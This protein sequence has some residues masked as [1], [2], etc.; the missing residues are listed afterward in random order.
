MVLWITK[1]LATCIYVDESLL[2]N[3]VNTMIYLILLAHCNNLTS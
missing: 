2:I 3:N 1:I